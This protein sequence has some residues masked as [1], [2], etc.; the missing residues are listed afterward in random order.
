MATGWTV[1]GPTNCNGGLTIGGA[2]LA[3]VATTGSYNSLINRVQAD[4]NE[5]NTTAYDY[6]KNKPVPFMVPPGV[7]TQFGGATAP[8]GYLLCD[9]TAYSRTTYA[10]L[11]A[12]IGSTFGA[13]D[14][15]TTF[16]VPNLTGKVAIGLLPNDANLGTL[17]QTGGSVSTVLS[18]SNLPSHTHTITDPG[19]NHALTD[20][21]HSHVTL[22]P[23]SKTASTGSVAYQQ[24]VNVTGSTSITS[25]ASTTG[26]TLAAASTGITLGMTGG[27]TPVVTLPPYLVV[28]YII[29]T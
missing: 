24:P 14:G 18:T 2:Q 4:W 16:A 19:H 17:G 20:P 29:K 10:N 1:N 22:Y 15:S 27:S 5:T 23:P 25:N 28:N 13:G 7:V 3:A 11:F 9:G 8:S 21:A 26:I 6:I 12:A